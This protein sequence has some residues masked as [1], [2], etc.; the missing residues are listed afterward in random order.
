MRMECKIYA[1]I[2]T[3]NAMKW[4]ERCF[5]SL[6]ES[7]TPVTPVVIDNG[8]TDDTISYIKEHF[9]E[10]HIIINSK[11]VGFGQAN[12]QGIQYAYKQGATHFLLLNQDAWIY[13]E[14]LSKLLSIQIENNIDLLSPIH[15]SGDGTIMDK[16]FF[17]AFIECDENKNKMVSSLLLD[18]RP[19]Y[20]FTEQTICAAAWFLPRS[21]IETIGGFDPIYFHYGED[22]NYIQRL[23]YH[24]KKVAV[25]P[26]AFILHDRKQH[27]NMKMYNKQSILRDLLVCYTDI[28][29][30]KLTQKMLVHLKHGAKFLIYLFTL[31]LGRCMNIIRSYCEFCKRIPIINNSKVHNRSIG[32]S[33]LSLESPSAI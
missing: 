16:D 1:I 15:L 21:T 31:K 33:W 25:C 24:Q 3:Y 5:M 17:Y 10:V 2:V 6:R 8:S 29:Y 4:A 30:V 9:P 26:N 27:G 13:T 20:F 14:T 7:I 19:D 11:N 28:N 32:P 18:E 23:K 22:N 12:N